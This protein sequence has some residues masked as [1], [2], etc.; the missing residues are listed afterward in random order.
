VC[1]S[2]TEST[3]RVVRGKRR[4]RHH[5]DRGKRER[6]S[7]SFFLELGAIPVPQLTAFRTGDRIRVTG[8][9]NQYCTLP[10]YDRFFQILIPGPASVAILEKA[11]MIRPPFLLATLM[12]ASLLLGIWWIRERRMAALRRQMRMLNALGEEVI[13]ATSPAEV[14][15][16]LT[17][18]L[19]ELS[20]A[21][22]IGMYILDRGTKTLETV[23]SASS[24]R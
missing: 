8:I 7:P 4:R 23:H 9:S 21:S 24:A 10:P 20:N 15:R 14:L 12:L 11:W 13:G 3:R 22:G 18:T 17:L 16:R 1:W 6:K 2:T 19:P 5:R